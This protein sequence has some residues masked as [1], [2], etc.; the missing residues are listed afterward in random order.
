VSRV[1]LIPRTSTKTQSAPASS[2][3]AWAPNQNPLSFA[4]TAPD[5][6]DPPRPALTYKKRSAFSDQLS[7]SSY[8]PWV[9]FCCCCFL[10]HPRL[11]TAL[12]KIICRICLVRPH[13]LIEACY[14]GGVS[15]REVLRILSPNQN[16]HAIAP[17]PQSQAL[18]FL[19]GVPMWHGR[20]ARVAPRRSLLCGLFEP[21]ARSHLPARSKPVSGSYRESRDHQ[22]YRTNPLCYRKQ[23]VED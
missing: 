3:T 6:C 1:S 4:S 18:S 20:P 13:R 12:E 23:R 10:L 17:I 11:E 16:H 22:N 8:H 14:A 9:A 15:Q 19:V 21:A 2:A 7:A 5:P